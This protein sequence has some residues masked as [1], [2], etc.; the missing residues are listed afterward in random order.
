MITKGMAVTIEEG[1]GLDSSRTGQSATVVKVVGCMAIVQLENGDVHG[2]VAD[3]LQPKITA[4][5][6]AA[7]FVGSENA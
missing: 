3:G 7:R 4:E 5:S 2:C 6:L 1:S